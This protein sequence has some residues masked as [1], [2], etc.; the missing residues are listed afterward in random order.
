MV[1][2]TLTLGLVLALA[3]CGRAP[4]ATPAATNGPLTAAEADLVALLPPGERQESEDATAINLTPPAP[5]TDADFA[6]LRTMLLEAREL[7]GIEAGFKDD[8]ELVPYLASLVRA[9]SVEV[10]DREGFLHQLGIDKPLSTGKTDWDTFPAV[11]AIKGYTPGAVFGEH[12][13]RSQKLAWKIA[14]SF[15]RMYTVLARAVNPALEATCRLRAPWK[16]PFVVHQTAHATGQTAPE[17]YKYKLQFDPDVH[18]GVPGTQPPGRKAY[19]TYTIALGLGFP[20]E[21][22]ARVGKTC[23]DVDEDGGVPYPDT[24]PYPGS[25]LDRHFNLD[26]KGQDTRLVWAKRHLAQA[27]AFGRQTAWV[28]AEIE[29]GVG[30]HSL[31]DSFAHGQLTPYLHG[32]IGEYPDDLRFNPIGYVEVA[33]ATQAYLKAYLNGLRSSSN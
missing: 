20:A 8:T 30:L 21:A 16:K 13:L 26:R 6:P 14:S 23:N 32:T 17:R 3:G 12:E 27:I 31:Q 25:G 10:Y 7:L 5:P 18:N 9:K 15:P 28:E 1:R 11:C 29:L 19:G 4:M 24:G 33:K 22:A 2:S